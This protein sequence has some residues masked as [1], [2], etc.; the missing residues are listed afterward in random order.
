MLQV[1][2]WPGVWALGDCAVVPDSRT[3]RYHPPTA[4]HAL[5]EGKVLAH[6]VTASVHGGAMKP[7]SF[8]PLASSR[9]SVSAPVWPTSSASTSPD[10]GLVAVP[11]DLLE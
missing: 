5:R 11:Y 6:N 10:H 7:F 4:R 8:Q 2:G 1:P 9:Q 3:G